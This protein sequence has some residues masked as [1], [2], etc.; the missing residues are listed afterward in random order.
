MP[1]TQGGAHAEVAK[2]ASLTTMTAFPAAHAWG[3]H[4][5][6]HRGHLPVDE[7]H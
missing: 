4:R 6:E 3:R 1:P 2:A 5:L 7:L